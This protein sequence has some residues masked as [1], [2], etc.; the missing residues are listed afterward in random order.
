[1][2]ILPGY[3]PVRDLSPGHSMDFPATERFY[4][5]ASSRVSGRE[6]K[7]SA[8]RHVNPR[9]RTWTGVLASNNGFCFA[10]NVRC[11][12]EA[13]VTDISRILDFPR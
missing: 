11:E 13:A 10:R 2:V 6:G 8:V 12:I 1:M 5:A 3:T 9:I 4:P 7:V